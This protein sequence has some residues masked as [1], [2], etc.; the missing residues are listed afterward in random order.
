M[1]NDW[2]IVNQD[3]YLFRR[4]LVKCCFTDS[5]K[6]DHAHCSFCWEKFGNA[7]GMTRMGYRVVDGPWWV[8]E[9]CFNDFRNRFEWKT[10]ERGQGD[11]SVVP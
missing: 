1:D 10:N 6:Y 8:C 9:N 2:R 7:E 3:K 5:E 11:G 4:H